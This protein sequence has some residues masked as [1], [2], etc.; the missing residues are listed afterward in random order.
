VFN[1]ELIKFKRFISWI[2]AKLCNLFYFLSIFNDSC[3]YQR[4]D[5]MEN[6]KKFVKF[7]ETK[8]AL[9]SRPWRRSSLCLCMERGDPCDECAPLYLYY[10]LDW[11]KD[12]LSVHPC[13]WRVYI[14]SLSFLPPNLFPMRVA[15]IHWFSLVPSSKPFSH[16]FKKKNFLRKTLRQKV[17]QM[18]ILILCIY[19]V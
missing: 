4:F 3:I 11:W 6:L 19:I 5:V 10:I 17:G 14:D 1:H 9:M 13:E 16:L 2:T 7:S 18:E 15:S 12:R 8:P